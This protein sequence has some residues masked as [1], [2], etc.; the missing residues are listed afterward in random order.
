MKKH[1]PRIKWVGGLT[2]DPYNPYPLK[3]HRVYNKRHKELWWWV[4]ENWE[5]F[6]LIG[7][8]IILL[9]MTIYSYIYFLRSGE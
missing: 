7:L 3:S 9:A 1:T 5:S 6:F 2:R 4:V 8:G